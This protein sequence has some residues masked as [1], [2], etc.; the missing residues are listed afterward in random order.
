MN[1]LPDNDIQA[2]TAIREKLI[3]AIMFQAPSGAGKTTSALILAYGMM[4][5][6]YPDLDDADIWQK[7]GVIDTEHK[8]SLV[9]VGMLKGEVVIGKFLFVEFNKPYSVQRSFACFN[10]LKAKGAEVIIFDSTSHVWE[11]TGGIQDYQQKLGGQ[12]QHWR[13]TNTDVYEP[14]IDLVTGVAHETTVINTSRTK[15]EHAMVQNELGRTE[16]KKLGMKPIQRDSLEYEFQIVFNIDMDNKAQVSK[17]NSGLFLGMNETITPAHGKLIYEW[18]D[19]GKDILAEK[20][21]IAEAYKQQC[22]GLASDIATQAKE[23]GL[24]EWLNQ[25][26]G[27]AYYQGKKLHDLELEDLNGIRQHMQPL[28][29]QKEAQGNA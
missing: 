23:F 2:V 14:F 28:M 18:L 26:L 19:E 16:V 4:K 1:A 24:V 17:D 12:F 3:G 5:A 29:E 7:I 6:K 13:K 11:G 20:R 15:Q 22:L 10:V 25:L 9:N 21:K 27:H 8:R